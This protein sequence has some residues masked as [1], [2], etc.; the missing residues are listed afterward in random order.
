LEE[1]KRLWILPVKQMRCL[2]C[3]ESS[4]A[5]RKPA[6]SPGSPPLGTQK[7][8]VPAAP[9]QLP[10]RQRRVGAAPGSDPVVG[11]SAS[12]VVVCVSLVPGPGQALP[13]MQD[14]ADSAGLRRG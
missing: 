2:A 14:G 6:K 1:Q 13:L 12:G 4:V 11:V 8:G 3:E 10:S 5:E 9:Y 7:Y